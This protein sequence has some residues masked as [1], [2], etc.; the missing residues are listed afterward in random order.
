MQLPSSAA[1][2]GS[3]APGLMQQQQQQMLGRQHGGQASSWPSQAELQQGGGPLPPQQQQQPAVGQGLAARQATAVDVEHM[4]QRHASVPANP[5]G[6]P[7]VYSLPMP[8]EICKRQCFIHIS[9]TQFA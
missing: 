2:P 6:G 7:C 3:M 9:I 8:S 5:L 4:Q 1:L